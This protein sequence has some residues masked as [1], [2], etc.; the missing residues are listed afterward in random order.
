MFASA[1]LCFVS[2][3]TSEQCSQF[4]QFH[5]PPVQL[6]N[7]TSRF[8]T[9]LIWNN[10]VNRKIHLSFNVPTF[11]VV[12]DPLQNTDQSILDRGADTLPL[13]PP[14]NERFK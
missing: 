5:P 2:I 3:Q 10:A 1:N 8:K 6:V 7:K 12:D 9:K 4:E 14:L 13:R 11:Y